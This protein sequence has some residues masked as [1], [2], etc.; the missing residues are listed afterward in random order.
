MADYFGSVFISADSKEVLMEEIEYYR[1]EN[2]KLN[3]RFKIFLA[4]IVPD[5]EDLSFT[6]GKQQMFDVTLECEITL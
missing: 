3:P 5:P 1:Q 4:K 2:E 6:K